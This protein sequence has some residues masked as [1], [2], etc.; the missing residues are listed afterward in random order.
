MELF[1]EAW[2]ETVMRSVARQMGGTLKAGRRRETVSPLAWDP[3]Y[4]G[5]QRSLVPDMI[6]ELD[7]RSFIVDAKYKR[8]WDP[9][10]TAAGR[11][12]GAKYGMEA[13]ASRGS[14]SSAGLRQPRER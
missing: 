14:A 4:T 1:F 11:V 10:Q 3:P 12:A 2:V 8:H 7:R 13:A 5:S 6:L 9:L